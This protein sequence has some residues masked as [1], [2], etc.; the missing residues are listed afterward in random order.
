MNAAPSREACFEAAGRVLSK[1]I[2]RM[3]STD[4]HEAALAAYIPRVTAPVEELEAR[5]RA[6]QAELR[7]RVKAA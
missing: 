4:P 3:L 2:I 5:I 1:G 6:R 7:D